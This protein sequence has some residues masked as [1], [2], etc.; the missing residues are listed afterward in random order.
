MFLVVAP[1]FLVPHYFITRPNE[2]GGS[3]VTDRHGYAYVSGNGF[4]SRIDPD[5]NLVYRN[6][7]APN[8]YPL[9]T[10]DSGGDLYTVTNSSV[11]KFDPA[12][13]VVY[14]FTLPAAPTSAPAIGPDGSAYFTGGGDT[15]GFPTTPGAWVSA[16]AAGFSN[17][18]VIK[19]SPGGDRIVYSTFIDNGRPNF[20]IPT[21]GLVIAVDAQGSAYVAGTTQNPNFPVTTGAYQTDCQCDK[22]PATFLTKLSS[23]GTALSYSALVEPGLSQVLFNELLPAAIQVDSAGN[24]MLLS[25]PSRSAPTYLELRRLSADGARLSLSTIGVP[26]A[27]IGNGAAPSIG[28]AA[29]DPEGNVLMTG[30]IT[31][32]FTPT[33]GAFREIAGGDAFIAIARPDD[34]ALIYS[35]ALPFDAERAAIAGGV[36]AGI[37]FLRVAGGFWSLNR[38]VSDTAARPGILGFADIVPGGLSTAI[39]PGEGLTLYGVNLGPA[40]AV[41]GGF[42]SNGRLPFALAGT[43]VDFGGTPAPLLSVSDQQ[44]TILA[45]FELHPG[46]LT[47]IRVTANG[48]TSNAA[49][50]LVN[51][52]AP[53]LFRCLGSSPFAGTAMA[54]NENGTVTCSGN[55]APTGSIV[56]VFLNGAGLI[57]PLPADGARGQ[58]GQAPVLPVTVSYNV[59][60]DLRY[61]TPPRPLD[62]LY[63]G[64]S[65]GAAAGIVQV[66]FRMPPS[67]SG[68]PSII[69]KL[70]VGDQSISA[71]IACT[72]N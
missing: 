23:D 53:N 48:Q 18:F 52:D 45:P 1:L 50:L 35:S 43:S 59:E 28:T 62:V 8:A 12:G 7:F 70:S 37:T 11:V 14:R 2:L 27:M 68:L 55:P 54:V 5:G 66:N 47:N 71:N 34:G 40:E 24:A 72:P 16:D 63:V 51:A 6:A 29:L 25:G 3:V 65:P 30:A 61:G 44:V 33:E 57:A 64:S 13:N 41:S 38:L 67:S 21:G 20:L 31:G 22:L 36:A 58:L 49:P 42:D 56:S 9:I 4:I 10:A 46:D 39:A 15:H 17:A 19:L 32:N 26:G 60:Y 69:L